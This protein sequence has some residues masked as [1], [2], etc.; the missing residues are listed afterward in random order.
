MAVLN[1]MRAV[2]K[3]ARMREKAGEIRREL[4]ALHKDLERLGDRIGR[5]DGHFRQAA[6]D[7]EDI[8]ISGTKAGTRAHRL[9]SFEF[10][11]VEVESPLEVVV[12]A[13]RDRP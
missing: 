5:L 7:I 6:Q 9:Q 3:D 8:K 1:T 13:Q 4:G 10:D 12:L 2:L 11:S